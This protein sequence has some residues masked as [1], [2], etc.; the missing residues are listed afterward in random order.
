MPPAVD[1]LV[2]LYISG[3]QSDPAPVAQMLDVKITAG[4]DGSQ[5]SSGHRF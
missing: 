5:R 4:S 2:G 1:D 3:W